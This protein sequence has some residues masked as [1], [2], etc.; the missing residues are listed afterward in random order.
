[1]MSSKKRAWKREEVGGGSFSP[2]WRSFVE[3]L[4]VN[5]LLQLERKETRRNE[6]QLQHFLVF[7]LKKFHQE[8]ERLERLEDKR[9]R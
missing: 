5:I 3:L 2:S 8:E 4:L 7:P 9:L 6:F 1:M